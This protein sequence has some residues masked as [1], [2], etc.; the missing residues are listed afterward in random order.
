VT[1][2][3]VCE[4][5]CEWE[6]EPAFGLLPAVT[7]PDIHLVAMRNGIYVEACFRCWFMWPDDHKIEPGR[8]PAE[9]VELAA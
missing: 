4:R 7:K 3:H 6:V 9:V 1:R 2:C 8:S 5:P